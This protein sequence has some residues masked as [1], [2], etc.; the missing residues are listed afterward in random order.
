MGVQ[1]RCEFEKNIQP[2]NSFILIGEKAGKKGLINNTGHGLTQFEYEEIQYWSD[3]VAL[4]KQD[5]SWQLID[6]FKNEK[7]G[8]KMK[9][10]H[11]VRNDD[12]EK[13]IIGLVE[14]GYG[15]FSNR[16]GEVISPTFND[17]INLGTD[18][19]PIYFTEK[20]VEE[21]EFYVVIYYD[22]D[23]NLLYKQAFEGKDYPLIY[24]EQ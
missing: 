18:K 19:A 5:Y 11:Y 2:Y 1:T 17:V 16:K 7:I 13:V 22:A 9:S 10:F 8:Q 12:V 4:V 20:H 23:G 24:C 3:S 6:I 14:N 21:A 15:V